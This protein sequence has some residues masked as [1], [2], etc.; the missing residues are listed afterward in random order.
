MNL[1]SSHVYLSIQFEAL[2]DRGV[3]DLNIIEDPSIDKFLS[4]LAYIEAKTYVN[5]AVAIVRAALLI[6]SVAASVISHMKL[7]ISQIRILDEIKSIG[8]EGY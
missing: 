1:H 5:I 6:T 2:I 3:R 4:Q 8:F 7:Q